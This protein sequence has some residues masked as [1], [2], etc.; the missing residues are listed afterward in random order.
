M[1][2]SDKI[3]SVMFAMTRRDE[4][5]SSHVVNKWNS[6]IHKMISQIC[7]DP[8]QSQRHENLVDT[9]QKLA[10]KSFGKAARMKMF[11]SAAAGAEG[12]CTVESDLDVCLS[13]GSRW[14]MKISDKKSTEKGEDLHKDV[15]RQEKID[16]LRVFERKIRRFLNFKTT[17]IFGA[18]FPIVTVRDD[19][20]TCVDISVQSRQNFGRLVAR[21]LKLY[22][23][24]EKVRKIMLFVKVWS[25]RR[26]INQ[27]QDNPSMPWQR[28]IFRQ[29]FEGTLNS[30]SL[31]LLLIYHLM[32]MKMVPDVFA[33]E[34]D[35]EPPLAV[36]RCADGIF[37]PVWFQT[38]EAKLAKDTLR[39]N[40]DIAEILCKFFRYFA[41]EHDW[42][43]RISIREDVVQPD[44]EVSK[45][46]VLWVADPLDISNNAA[47]CVDEEGLERIR[48]EFKRASAI[49]E[50]R[51]GLEEI[52]K[53]LGNKER[54]RLARRLEEK[55]RTRKKRRR[56]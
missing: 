48:S 7:I 15:W 40:F 9:L 23:R 43:K 47:R 52:W 20:G 49:F 30:F 18:R 37:R 34:G 53:P 32:R 11:G 24:D 12:L 1:R 6:D 56:S 39:Q 54:K 25:K 27:A 21:L 44:N 41:L 35:D 55:R 33:R 50:K 19:E 4:S 8:E 45:D 10:K 3:P 17:C 22:T 31:S 13:L 38:D 42:S 28:V 36:L 2:T 46:Y 29:A 14:E 51:E 16:I 5:S 26:S